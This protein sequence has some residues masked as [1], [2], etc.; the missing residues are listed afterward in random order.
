MKKFIVALGIVALF[1]G[2]TSCKKSYICACTVGT[3][4]VSARTITDT[5]KNATTL[6]DADDSSISG[7]VHDCE[8]Q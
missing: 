7:V 4:E 5:K 3:T 8:I 2:I 1:A 6:C